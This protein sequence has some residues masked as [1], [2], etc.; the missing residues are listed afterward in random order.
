MRKLSEAGLCG[1]EAAAGSSRVARDGGAGKTRSARCRQNPR[2]RAQTGRADCRR[3][4]RVPVVSCDSA[5]LAC[6]PGRV[7]VNYC[8]ECGARLDDSGIEHD[9]LSHDRSRPASAAHLQVFGDRPVLH[10]NRFHRAPGQAAIIVGR[11]GVGKSTSDQSVLRAGPS[12]CGPFAVVR[13]RSRSGWR[14]RNSGA[15]ACCSISHCF[16]PTC[17]P[18]RTWNFTARFIA[19]AEP[20]AHAGNG[21]NGW[22]WNAPRMNRSAPCRGGWNSAWGLP[23]H[24]RR[25]RPDSAR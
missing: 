11:N 7:Q 5:R 3:R 2:R 9:A 24:A 21:W 1:T 6:K 15:W 14:R 12:Q 16:I 17:R 20:A 23:A 8:A 19:L 10:G 22:V 18:V 13:R 25:S 4:R